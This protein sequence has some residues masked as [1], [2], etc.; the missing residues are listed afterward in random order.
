MIVRVDIPRRLAASLTV[1]F[2]SKH[3][4]NLVHMLLRR[5]RSTAVPVTS[6]KQRPQ[7]L[8]SGA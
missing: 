4:R 7:A 2:S 5:S 6:V 3:S 8:H 1:S